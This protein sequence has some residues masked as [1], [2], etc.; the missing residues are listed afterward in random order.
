[1][2]LTSEI[3]VSALVRRIF[4]DGGFAAVERRGA[5]EAGAVFVRLRH[6]DG[7]QSLAAPAPQVLIPETS[8]PG[9]RWFEL[10]MA[11]EPAE[12]VEALL[13]REIRFDG[14]LWVVEIEIEADRADGYL[15]LTP[16]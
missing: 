15:T 9:E 10:R 14:D 11:G 12:T 7:T 8:A 4:A 5:R 2:R 1:M 16:A 6:R 13:E 3:W